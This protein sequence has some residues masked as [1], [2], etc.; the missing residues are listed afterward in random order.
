MTIY[1]VKQVWDEKGE[2]LISPCDMF[3]AIMPRRGVTRRMIEHVAREAVKKARAGRPVDEY[4]DVKPAVRK[5]LRSMG[6]V[7]NYGTADI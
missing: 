2:L 7:R 3:I 1:I 4:T 6:R 5:A